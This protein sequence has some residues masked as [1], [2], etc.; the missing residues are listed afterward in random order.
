MEH[1]AAYVALDWSDE[2]HDVA[3]LDAATDRRETATIKHSAQAIDEWASRLRQ[4]FAGQ[5]VAVC[6]EQSRGPLIYALLKYDFFVLYP[7]NPKTLAKYREAFSPSGA[8]DDPTDTDYLLDILIHHR[9]RLKPWRPDDEKT[10]TLQY[11]V[12]HRRKLVNDRTRI[13]NRMT[14]L[15]KLYF[16]QV[17][18][19]FDDLCTVIVC[20]FLLRW[21]TL[22]EVKRAQKATLE[23]FFHAHH[24]VRKETNQ[25]RIKEIKEAIPLVTDRAVINSSVLIVRALCAQLQAT[26]SAIQEFDREIEA[27]CHSHQDFF[28]FE[29]LPGAGP[30]YASRLAVAFGTDRSRWSKVDELLCLSGIAPVIER[31]GKSEWIRWRYFCPKFLRQSFH[32]YA[33]ESLKHSFWARAYYDS[34]RAKGKS[35]QAAV[36]ALAFKWIRIMWK[37]WQTRTA[38]DEVKYLESLRKKGSSLLTYAAQ[39][40]S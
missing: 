12:E 15:L 40:K 9:D 7:I 21:S 23:R 24:S 31:S 25:R 32:E 5:K 4:R 13:N 35:H 10:R 17:L 22:D 34:Q 26:L 36:R 2:K 20:D 37:C 14:A 29:S 30:V 6:L 3:L 11:L 19:W 16:P 8:K 27:L 39:A 33:G 1:F 28:I 18:A 38:Y